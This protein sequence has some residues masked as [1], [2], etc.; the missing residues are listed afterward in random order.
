VIVLDHR[1]DQFDLWFGSAEKGVSGVL[2]LSPD[3]ASEKW[4]SQFEQCQW[5]MK[6]EEGFQ[7]YRCEKWQDEK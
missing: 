1:I 5:V 4:V 3:H 7:F 6:T 2:L